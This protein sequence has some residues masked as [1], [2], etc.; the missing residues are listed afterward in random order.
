MKLTLTDPCIITPG[1]MAGVQVGSGD[2][3]GWVGIEYSNNLRDDHRTGYHWQIIF[4][5][6]EFHGDDLSSG[7]GGLA[8]ALESLLDFLVDAAES[9]GFF[10]RN[11]E[12]KRD[13][14]GLFPDA[15][16]Q[17]ASRHVDEID[18]YIDDIQERPTCIME[19][20]QPA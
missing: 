5:G 17:W 12:I 7:A 16:T 20:I 11:P 19:E 2:D 10:D 13:K 9:R 1:L 6:Q 15:V 3:I 8:A 18:G 14:D 4:G